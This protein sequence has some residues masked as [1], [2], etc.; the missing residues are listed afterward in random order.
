MT[1]SFLSWIIFFF[2][3]LFP[4]YT[5]PLVAFSDLE[6]SRSLCCLRFHRFRHLASVTLLS[7]KLYHLHSGLSHTLIYIQ[8]L[9]PDQAA[10]SLNTQTVGTI[11]A[12][13]TSIQTYYSVDMQY[14]HKQVYIY[15]VYTLYILHHIQLQLNEQLLLY[16]YLIPQPR[17]YAFYRSRSGG[18]TPQICASPPL[19]FSS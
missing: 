2:F 16:I 18:Q 7:T 4:T 8:L 12:Q 3:S 9:Q 1:F 17:K 15:T 5:S 10:H 13:Q 14:V 11:I 6:G 19:F